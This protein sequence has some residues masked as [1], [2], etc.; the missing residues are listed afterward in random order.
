MAWN[1]ED[2]RRTRLVDSKERARAKRQAQ[3]GMMH[4]RMVAHLQLLLETGEPCLDLGSAEPQAPADSE[5]DRAAA[6]GAQVVDGLLA[7]LQFGGEVLE[8]VG[9]LEGAMDDVVVG[10]SGGG[11]WSLHAPEVRTW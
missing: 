7:H 11:L 2:A 6:L 1:Q 4:E 10:I 9:R 5:A 8:R 3:L